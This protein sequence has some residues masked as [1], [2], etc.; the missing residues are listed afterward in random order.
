MF[1]Y[2]AGLG[3]P[4]DWWTS[5]IHLLLKVHQFD[6]FFDGIPIPDIFPPEIPPNIGKNKPYNYVVGL[7]DGQE[8]CGIGHLWTTLILENSIIFFK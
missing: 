7:K 1:S 2:N 3:T 8:N 5:V 6:L 4:T